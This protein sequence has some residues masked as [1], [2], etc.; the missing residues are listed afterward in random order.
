MALGQ[1]EYIQLPQQKQRRSSHDLERSE[2]PGRECILNLKRRRVCAHGES[3]VGPVPVSDS[4]P[5]PGH[6]YI[7]Q[8]EEEDGHMPTLV[9]SCW[10]T[11][12]K[13]QLL[14]VSMLS[15]EN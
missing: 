9:L 1:W 11:A 3:Q 6:V 15:P 10:V 4:G 5:I 13:K 12:D 14:G 8:Q 7:L 2:P